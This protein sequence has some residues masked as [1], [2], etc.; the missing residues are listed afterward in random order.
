M[1]K[2]RFIFLPIRGFKLVILDSSVET[3]IFLAILLSDE[4]PDRVW[5]FSQAVKFPSR[6]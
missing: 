1:S 6:C 5:S 3:H 4:S 2:V